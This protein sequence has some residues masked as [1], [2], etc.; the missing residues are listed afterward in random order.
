[1]CIGGSVGTEN[2]S[3]PAPS[4]RLL[5]RAAGTAPRGGRQLPP[6]YGV[7]LW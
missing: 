3:Q 6:D 4:A 7:R 2:R 1:M 5:V